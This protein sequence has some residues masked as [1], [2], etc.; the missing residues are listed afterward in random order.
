[1]AHSAQYFTSHTQLDLLPGVHHLNTAVIIIQNVHNFSLTGTLTSNG[2]I[3]TVI[4]CDRSGLAGGIII[5]NSTFTTIKNLMINN[6]NTELR[7]LLSWNIQDTLWRKNVST[8]SLVLQNSY[9]IT[10]QQIAIFTTCDYDIILDNVHMNFSGVYSKNILVLYGS[11]YT[12]TQNSNY[13]LVITDY[14]TNDNNEWYKIEIIL[15]NHPYHVEIL[16]SHIEFQVQNAIS[17]KT[18][19]CSGSNQLKIYNCKFSNIKSHFFTSFVF[20]ESGSSNSCGRNTMRNL[21]ELVDCQ[22]TNNTKY[23]MK[24]SNMF[25]IKACVTDSHSF[26]FMVLHIAHCKFENNI[27]ISILKIGCENTDTVL[28]IVMSLIFENVTFRQIETVFDAVLLELYHA[29]L[30][31]KGP[32]LF[33]SIGAYSI[34]HVYH[35]KISLK[36][37]I[38]FSNI[39]VNSVISSDIAFLY[40]N[41]T[42]NIT[43]S[44]ILESVIKVNRKDF[45]YPPCVLQYYSDNEILDGSDKLSAILITITDSK[46]QF[47]CDVK[48]CLSHCSWYS[49]ALFQMLTP[50]DVNRRIVHLDNQERIGIISDE[51]DI[52][53]CSDDSQYDCLLDEINNVYPGQTLQF[54]LL[55]MNGVSELV[56]V[57]SA[58]PTSCRI[59]KSS[60]ISQ[61]VYNNCTKVQYTFHHTKRWCE[62]FLSTL[63]HTKEVFYVN[64]LPCPLSFVLH[65]EEGYCHCDPVLTSTAIISITSCNINDQTILRPPNSWISANNYNN[66]VVYEVSSTCPFDYCLPHSSHL[67]LFNP[68]SQCQFNRTGLLCGRCRVGLSAVF[69]TSQY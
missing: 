61:V 29:L 28:P 38:E 40:L 18:L 4:K 15:F 32:V 5:S 55:H 9:Y 60:E 41:T 21:I 48:Y 69:G 36:N 19:T 52:C 23:T 27:Q 20:L 30:T 13:K 10:I 1:V 7:S 37:Y 56:I 17:V 26:N 42:I 24:H 16:I 68:D 14:H 34:M 2:T 12:V 47:L 50:L 11:Y 22:F 62:L 35:T 58:P 44:L 66:S 65:P 45:F 33:T 57:N 59:V 46:Y 31:F 51:K 53:Y 67:N 43:K 54:N 8:I 25:M 39:V 3:A 6:C 64:L 49:G 63:S